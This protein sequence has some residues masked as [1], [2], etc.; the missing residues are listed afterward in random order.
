[1]KKRKLHPRPGK[2]KIR[3]RQNFRNVAC[4]FSGCTETL[5]DVFGTEPIHP[6]ELS[7]LLW[8]YVKMK[9]LQRRTVALMSL[10]GRQPVPTPPPQPVDDIDDINTYRRRRA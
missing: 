9:N 10:G 7:R 5:E 2:T 8:Q 3:R 6:G 1:M 4:D